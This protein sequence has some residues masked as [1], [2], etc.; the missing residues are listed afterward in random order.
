MLRQ[1]DTANLRNTA[2]RHYRPD[3]DGLRAIAVLPVVAFHAFPQ[4]FPGGFVGVDVFF[5]ISGFLI[6][7]IIFHELHAK[8]FSLRGFYAR[9]VRRL[10][11]ALMVVLAAILAAGWWAL[12]PVE[13][14]RLGQQVVTSVAFVANLYLWFQA[15][16]FDPAA[17]TYPLL[18][19]WSLGVEEQFYIFW[20]LLL[21][22]ASKRH[23]SLLALTAVVCAVSF[24][25]NIG[26]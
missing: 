16:Y 15:R 24:A 20:P 21:W 18:H 13:L 9:R 25:L 3:I 22:F 8:S 11:P 5:V 17:N 7:Q 10:F 2:G 4:I 12:L 1:T 6:S 19:L 26:T 23:L 14:I